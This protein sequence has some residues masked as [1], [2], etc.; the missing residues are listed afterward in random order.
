MS[1]SD[2]QKNAWLTEHQT[3]AQEI[4]DLLAVVERDL[5]D[6]A[7]K[8]LSADWR[9]NIAYNAALQ[10]AAAA[11][12]ACGY[13]AARD[14]HHFR[15]IESLAETIGADPKT[16]STFDAYRQEAQRQQLRANRHGL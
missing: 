14:N 3:S 10:A 6:S 5:S 8:G 9:L 11:L 4:R 16:V 1:L 13:R 7:A 2:W 12:A 15:T